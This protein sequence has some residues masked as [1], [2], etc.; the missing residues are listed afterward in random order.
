MFEI[1]FDNPKQLFQTGFFSIFRIKCI[2][3]ANTNLMYVL[4]LIE[5]Y[6]L[7]K[8]FFGFFLMV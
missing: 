7:F 2:I 4:F 8:S 1:A 6:E 3:S 5:I